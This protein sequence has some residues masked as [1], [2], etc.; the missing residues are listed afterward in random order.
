MYIIGMQTF[1]IGYIGGNNGCSAYRFRNLAQYVNGI[2]N[3]KYRFLEPPFEVSDAIILSNTAAIVFKD[4]AG[5]MTTDLIRHYKKLREENKYHYK[6]VM[7]FDDLPYVMGDGGAGDVVDPVIRE[8]LDKIQVLAKEMDVITA[9]TEFLANQLKEHGL[10]NVKIIP[11]VVPRYLW[12]YPVHKLKSKPLVMYA[13][14]MSHYGNNGA[15]PDI[16]E[17][18]ITFLKMGVEQDVFNLMVVGTESQKNKFFGK[19]IGKKIDSIQWSHIISYPSVV[20]TISPDFF[21]APLANVAFNKAK[22]NVK[23]L[24]SAAIGAVFMGDVFEG[25]P[26]QGCLDCQSV[27]ETD[28]PKTIMEKFKFLCKPENFYAVQ[29]AQ[30]D[31]ISDNDLFTESRKYIGYYLRVVAG[32][33]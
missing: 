32:E 30:A 7:D 26:Y 9:S 29:K 31:F 23:M 3:S 10:P 6:L 5:Q 4:D 24:E 25:S 16:N 18:W 22:S 12:G 21:I 19:K 27:T 11:N 28:T 15:V 17:K 14:S 20:R 33:L 1:I 8:N 13:G 2:Q